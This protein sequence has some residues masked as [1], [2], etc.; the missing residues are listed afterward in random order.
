MNRGSPVGGTLSRSWVE[1]VVGR[2]AV[3]TG[4]EGG[5]E[6]EA[7]VEV[8]VE[9]EAGGEAEVEVMYPEPGAEAEGSAA[10]EEEEEGDSQV[11]APESVVLDVSDRETPA[12]A[13]AAASPE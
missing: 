13:A 9:T 7:E 10:E 3:E 1:G 2:A 8:G 11:V 4:A 6:V 5:A 12:S